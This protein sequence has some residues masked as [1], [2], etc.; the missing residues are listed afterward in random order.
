MKEVK[1]DRGN[2]AFVDDEDYE[3]LKQHVWWTDPQRNTCYAGANIDGRNQRM[4]RVI[5]GYPA[6]QVDHR[7]GN[8]LNNQRSNLRLA[9]HSQNQHNAG[10][11]KDNSSGYKGV[12]RVTG[13]S[14]LWGVQVK[15]IYLGT[16]PSAEQAARAYDA[17]A[18]ELYGE[19]ARLNFPAPPEP[20]D[21]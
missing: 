2:V 11:R 4:H 5:M 18:V 20:K 1:L 6:T 3:I 10:L 17:K 15:R 7:D 21:E 12:Y 9:T 13:A 16:F 8:G 19:F 14:N